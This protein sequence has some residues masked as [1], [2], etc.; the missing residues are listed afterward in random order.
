MKK[1]SQK[2]QKAIKKYRKPE[3]KIEKLTVLNTDAIASPV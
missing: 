2:Q 3:V 1:L